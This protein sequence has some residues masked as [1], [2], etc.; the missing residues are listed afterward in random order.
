MRKVLILT[1]DPSDQAR[2]RLTD[3]LREIRDSRERAPNKDEFVLED[4]VGARPNDLSRTMLNSYPA[5]VHFSGHGSGPGGLILEDEGG[6]SRLVPTDGLTRLFRLFAD[7]GLECVVLNSCLSA[8]QAAE[9]VRHV[10]YVV[11]MTH[12]IGDA[13]AIQF[14][15]GFYTAVFAG[16]P[17]D[18]AFAFGCHSIQLNGLPVGI[19]QEVTGRIVST[20]GTGIIHALPEHL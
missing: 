19:Q 12:E 1:A 5:V 13:A 3:E 11:G 15:A 10:P 7:R 4:Y 8:E 2:L 6:R 16:E 14:S 18:R 9:I 17:F 20:G